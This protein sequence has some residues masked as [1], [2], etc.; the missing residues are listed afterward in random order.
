MS[1][2][3]ELT[4]IIGRRLREVCQGDGDLPDKIRDRL[5]MLCTAEARWQV[6]QNRLVSDAREIT[7]E[8]NATADASGHG[9]SNGNGSG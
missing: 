8:R 5:E 3:Q 9:S 7:C 1:K 6:E 2:N 4:Q